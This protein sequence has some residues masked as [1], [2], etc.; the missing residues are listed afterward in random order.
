MRGA[1]PVRLEAAAIPASG[2]YPD[3]THEPTLIGEVG[4]NTRSMLK[5]RSGRPR[6]CTRAIR[7]REMAENAVSLPACSSWGRLLAW[8]PAASTD[9]APARP[10]RK[11]YP[12]ISVA[13][14]V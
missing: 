4:L 10:P 12:A 1:R 3:S 2:A 8:A 11:R 14:Q 9:E 5:N 13:A 7:D 6:S